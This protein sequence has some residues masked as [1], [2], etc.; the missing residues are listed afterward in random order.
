V[1][2]QLWIDH[3]GY[4]K[5]CAERYTPVRGKRSGAKP[6]AGCAFWTSTHG[7]EDSWL[8]WLVGEDWFPG[9]GR[10]E[11]HGF[12][13]L[14]PDPAARVYEINTLDDLVALLRDYGVPKYPTI[15]DDILAEDKRP[16]F[17]AMARDGF[18]GVHLTGE[19]Q[20]RT[21][22]SFPSLYGW[23]CESTLWFRWA[24]TAARQITYEEAR[25]T[26][27]VVA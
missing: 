15:P 8:A 19:G 25:L 17:E 7:D 21:R 16:D 20:W 9:K 24:F 14:E 11:D 1:K 6:A 10:L 4:G 22:L 13:L 26:T 3:E 27:S 18:D 12:W 2:T 23:D 5:P